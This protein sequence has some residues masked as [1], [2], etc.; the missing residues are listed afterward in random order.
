MR[1]TAL[2]STILKVK[3]PPNYEIFSKRFRELKKVEKLWLKAKFNLEEVV[4][5]VVVVAFRMVPGQAD[6]LVHVEGLDVLEGHFSGATIFNLGF[7]RL[8]ILDL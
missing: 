7:I 5:H 8:S 4:E 2:N 6:V 1:T 3:F